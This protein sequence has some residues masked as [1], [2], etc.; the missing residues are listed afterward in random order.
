M[1]V[2]LRF[3]LHR[4]VV[5]ES[6]VLLLW[7]QRAPAFLLVTCGGLIQFGTF[8]VKAFE[9]FSQVNPSYF[10]GVPL[11]NQKFMFNVS[12]DATRNVAES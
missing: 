5:E 8:P 7:H 9:C 6:T 2:A 1:R 3:V 11:S 10:K 4:T 12:L